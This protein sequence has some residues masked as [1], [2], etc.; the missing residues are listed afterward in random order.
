M[1]KLVFLLAAAIFLLS[2]CA[3]TTDNQRFV[4]IYN[5]EIYKEA[6]NWYPINP[7]YTSVRAWVGTEEDAS[8]P[9]DDLSKVLLANANP[10]HPFIAYD[11]QLSETHYLI[12]GDDTL[13]DVYTDK[14]EKIVLSRDDENTVISGSALESLVDFLR[15]CH[16]GTISYQ[17]EK[18][19]SGAPDQLVYI[20]FEEFPLYYYYGYFGQSESG[21][22]GFSSWDVE[23]YN[24]QCI[25]LP[26]AVAEG[27]AQ[28]EKAN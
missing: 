22:S 27:I 7:T 3:S 15:Q 2:G 5:N 20:Y 14:I 1:K 21:K 24:T 11:N 19:K 23:S 25:L 12:K 4:A 6:P 10:T 26:D 9:T 28:S 17:T 16:A 18:W 8:H 13:P